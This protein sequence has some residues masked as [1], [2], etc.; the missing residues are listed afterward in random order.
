MMFFRGMDILVLEI[1]VVSCLEDG[2]IFSGKKSRPST[3]S[4]EM[5]EYSK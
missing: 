1:S 4:T 2:G 3:D 5:V